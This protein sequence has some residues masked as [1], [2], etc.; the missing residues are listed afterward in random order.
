MRRCSRLA[1]GWRMLL[2]LLA[3]LAPHAPLSARLVPP[4]PPLAARVRGMLAEAMV[5]REAAERRPEPG[6][7]SLGPAVGEGHEGGRRSWLSACRRIS[8]AAA[9]EAGARG[10]DSG[11]AW[12]GA[13]RGERRVGCA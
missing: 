6:P 3:P 7:H 8:L 2:A 10:W 11:G 9:G 13:A 5:E 4:P 1:T 12:K